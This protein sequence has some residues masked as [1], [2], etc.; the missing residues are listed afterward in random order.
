MTQTILKKEVTKKLW[1]ILGKLLRIDMYNRGEEVL[2]I[3]YGMDIYIED[4][5]WLVDELLNS[6][7]KIRTLEAELKKKK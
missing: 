4:T 5:S 7:G 2:P 1:S 6:Y 3:D